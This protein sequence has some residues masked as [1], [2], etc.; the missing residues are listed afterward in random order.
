LFSRSA[1]ARRSAL[2]SLGTPSC[3]A[4]P[5][6]FVGNLSH[7]RWAGGTTICRGTSDPTI[8]LPQPF[9]QRLYGSCAGSRPPRRRLGVCG[10][11]PR[12]EISFEANLTPPHWHSGKSANQSRTLDGLCRLKTALRL[13]NHPAPGAPRGFLLSLCGV[14]VPSL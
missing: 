2:K 11:L 13:R 3:G 6:Q 10:Q 7:G 1:N 12:S 4:A 9:S 14:C 5:V 8:R